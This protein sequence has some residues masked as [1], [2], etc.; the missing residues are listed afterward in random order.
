MPKSAAVLFDLDGTLVDS[1]PPMTRAL[2]RLVLRRGVS[3]V[4][5]SAVRRWISLGGETML[6]GALGDQV[7]DMA[8]TLEEFR[9]ILRNDIAD[10]ADLFP[11]TIEMLKNLKDAGHARGIC[12]NKREDI[13]VPY[14]QGLGISEYFDGYIVG[15]APGR[16]LKPAPF[17]AEML[18]AK[19]GRDLQDA[20]FVGDSEVDAE[21]AAAAGIPFVLVTFGYPSG[22]M[23]AIA[24]AA[25]VDDF[26]A[27]T[28]VIATLCEKIP[29]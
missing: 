14:A 5:V 7:G 13:A 9:D 26:Y 1:A 6:R 19:M 2:N 29:C 8:E 4:D 20:I 3:P 27:L 10:P 16:K 11:G 18:L 25:R 23:S 28:G 12:T 15:G 22:E 21:T 17:V 24:A